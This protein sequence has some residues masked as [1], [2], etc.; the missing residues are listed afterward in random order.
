M[1]TYAMLEFAGITCRCTNLVN[2]NQ[3]D[4]VAASSRFD[5]QIVSGSFQDLRAIATRNKDASRWR[6]SLLGWR[7]LLVVARTLLVDLGR[8]D[9]SGPSTEHC[10]S[11]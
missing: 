2:L 10:N 3:L 6:P 9:F 11:G 1:H 4:P 5:F 7:P 8:R